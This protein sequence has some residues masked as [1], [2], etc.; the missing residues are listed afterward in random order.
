M[1]VANDV[2]HAVAPRSPPR[3]SGYVH[4]PAAI[5]QEAHKVSSHGA[6]AAKHQGPHRRLL[7]IEIALPASARFRTT[8]ATPPSRESSTRRPT[9]SVL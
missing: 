3:A 9:E 4:G 1:R 8:N 7:A 2:P 5:G 6:R